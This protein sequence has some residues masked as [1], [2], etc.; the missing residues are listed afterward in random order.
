V[1]AQV[2]RHEPS[3]LSEE[4]REA[5]EAAAE[6]GDPVQADDDRRVRLAPLVDV[7][8]Q[9]VSSPLPDGR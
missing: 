2:G 7:E 6:R 4:V 1:A 5:L 8:P 3:A 9:S